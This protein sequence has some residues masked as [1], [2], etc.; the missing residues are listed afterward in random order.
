MQ[1]KNESINYLDT[2]E[3]IFV[4]NDTTYNFDFNYENSE[5]FIF[6]KNL[7]KN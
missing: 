7:N 6:L 3:A 1:N 4:N 5:T 2:N